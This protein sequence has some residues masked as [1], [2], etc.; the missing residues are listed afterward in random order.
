MC[1]GTRPFPGIVARV[2]CQTYVRAVAHAKS[3]T[4]S[5]AKCQ[6]RRSPDGGAAV[7]RPGPTSSGPTIVVTLSESHAEDWYLWHEDFVIRGNDGD[8]K[9]KGGTLELLSANL[10][11]TLFTITFKHMGI[12]KLEPERVETHSESIHRVTAHLYVED[13]QFDVGG[14]ASK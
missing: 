5:A 1:T 13:M 14:A 8:D 11:E 4:V 10:Q 3:F 6:T 7:A 12:F 2:A 9:E